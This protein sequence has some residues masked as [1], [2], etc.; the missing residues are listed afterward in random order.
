M[1]DSGGPCSG[2]I[3]YPGAG[4]VVSTGA[5]WGTSLIA[6]SGVIVGT[7]D[8]QTLTNK[9][10]DGVT[11]TT[12]G[13]LDATSSIQTQLNGKQTTLTNPVTGPGSGATVGHLAVMGNTSGTS[14]TDGGAVPTLS[15]LGASFFIYDCEW[16]CTFVERDSVGIRPHDRDAS[17]H[18]QSRLIREMLR[19]LAAVVAMTVKGINGT[20]LSGLATG[21]LKN[22]TSTGVPVI[23]TA[24]TDYVV[25][26]GSI[27]GTAANVT[28][29]SNSS[30]TTLSALSLPYSQLSGAV[31]T[32]NQSTTGNAATASLA[33]TSN[34]LS[35]TPT[36]G[37]YWGY[38]GSSQGWNTPAGGGN[39]S[40]SGTPTS[41]QYA[42]WAN[43]T[44]IQGQTGVLR[45]A[46]GYGTDMEPGHKWECSHGFCSGSDTNTLLDWLCADRD[47]GQW[48]CDGVCCYRWRE[49]DRASL[50][51]GN[52]SPLFT[53]SVATA[54]T[55]PAL[56]FTLSS[57]AQNSVL[58]GPA[59]GGAG[60]PSYQTAPT[61]SAANMTNFPTLNQNTTGNAATAT[62][63]ATATN[64][65]GTG[66]DYAP[67]QSA[68]GTTSYIAAPTTSGHTFV[69]GWQPSGSAVSSHGA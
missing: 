56:S 65:A 45:C 46:D 29:T 63:A 14:I 57:A 69:Y 38:N 2:N 9:T 44:A 36:S 12:M 7:T 31:P 28:A 6:P 8:T 25:P 49:R 35:G 15:S 66:V 47:S 41:G 68:S 42:V 32:W 20:T 51:A 1:S 17:E 50:S 40:N 22:T 24:G 13:Y 55:T 30:L 37:Q 19:I 10:I 16:P 61:I 33:T 54:T 58:A 21:L 18:Q 48:E 11:P 52:L 53:S 34:G 62:T 39:V 3:V 5:A 23:A 27:T 60:A 43:A 4:V 26:S 59:S 64:L 67:F